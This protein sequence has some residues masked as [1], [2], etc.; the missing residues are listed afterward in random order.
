MAFEDSNAVDGKA[1]IGHQ[2]VGLSGVTCVL[3]NEK[4]NDK[5]TPTPTPTPTPEPTPDPNVAAGIALAKPDGSPL[6]IK[7]GEGNDFPGL[8]VANGGTAT[9]AVSLAKMP[10]DDVPINVTKPYDRRGRI[11]FSPSR[12]DFTSD[13]WNVAQ[14]VTVNSSTPVN[15]AN[16]SAVIRLRTGYTD[17]LDY[18]NLV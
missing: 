1:S 2:V 15:A 13:N 18:Y 12:L 16:G 10:T 14:T 3:V 5:P 6:T 17:D 4:D 11:S 7:D 9:F 8:Y